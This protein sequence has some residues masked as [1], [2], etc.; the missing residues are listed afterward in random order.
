MVKLPSK[1]VFSSFAYSDLGEFN[2]AT[3]L[4]RKVTC[5]Y[6]LPVNPSP[7]GFNIVYMKFKGALSVVIGTYD[8]I[9]TKEKYLEL[10]SAL[11][12]SLISGGK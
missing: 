6:N 3:F 12:E 2:I 1:G 11:K 5:I 10:E 8:S 4:E 7:P 9:F